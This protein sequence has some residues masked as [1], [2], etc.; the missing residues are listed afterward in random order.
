MDPPARDEAKSA[1]RFISCPVCLLDCLAQYTL[2]NAVTGYFVRMVTD[3][4]VPVDKQEMIE[5]LVTLILGYF[6]QRSKRAK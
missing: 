4:D 1:K 6:N 3:Q 2:T 5:E